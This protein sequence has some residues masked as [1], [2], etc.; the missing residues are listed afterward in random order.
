MVV[1]KNWC[2]RTRSNKEYGQTE[3][4]RDGRKHVSSNRDGVEV[5]THGADPYGKSIQERSTIE[6]NQLYHI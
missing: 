5:A 3:N 4:N 6:S 2:S 1:G